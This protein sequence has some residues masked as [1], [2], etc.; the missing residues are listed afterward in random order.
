MAVLARSALSAGVDEMIEPLRTLK[1]LSE[2]EDCGA[3]HK[4]Y[5]E[6]ELKEEA[7]KW[8]KDMEAEQP[9][10]EATW[11]AIQWAKIFFNLED[12]DLK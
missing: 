10:K 9:Y 8:V 12:K 6:T 2:I 11:A 5:D 7:I 4:T 1:K 3:G